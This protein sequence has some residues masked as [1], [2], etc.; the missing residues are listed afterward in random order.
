MKYKLKDTDEMY[1]KVY[2]YNSR[3]VTP[4]YRD[5]QDIEKSIERHVDD[6]GNVECVQEQIYTYKENDIE[7]EAD[8]LIKLCSDIAYDRETLNDPCRWKVQ[9][10]RNN[11]K[12]SA[13]A[14]GL[15]ELLDYVS[16]YNCKIVEGE[17]NE[18]QK[19]LVDVARDLY[20]E[21]K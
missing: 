11:E 17:L 7:Y 8:S 18:T 19:A 5:L 16:R 10:A 2:P 6:I 4:T 13:I 1:V 21:S 20:G 15:E 3:F 14:W 9:W 12:Y